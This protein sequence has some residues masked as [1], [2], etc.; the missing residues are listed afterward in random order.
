MK[1]DLRF[2]VGA[3]ILIL[4][5]AC[6]API[7]QAVRATA[8]T[9]ASP[10]PTL[11]ATNTIIPSAAVSPEL[12]DWSV[13]NPEAVDIKSDN[14]SLILTLKYRVLWFMNQRGVLV[15]KPVDG[16]FKITADVHTSK[17]SASGLPPG[18]DGTVQLGGLMARNGNGAQENYVFIVV[19]DDGDGLSIETKNTTDS[20]SAYNGPSWD[21]AGAQLRLCRFGQTFHLYKRHIGGNDTW[22]LAETFD[23]P[24]LPETLQAGLNI[25]TDS[26]PDLQVRYENIKI[27]PVSTESDCELN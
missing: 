25:Y 12:E 6:A 17:S 13:I 24:N 16:N 1:I 11:T 14:G 26:T 2:I 18:G 22:M 15:Y 19:G 4:L 27:E 3:M 21:S 8:T 23:R 10:P 5:T 20:V 9:T 7:P